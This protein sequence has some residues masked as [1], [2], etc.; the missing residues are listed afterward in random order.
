MV[1]PPA[2]N[3]RP[4]LGESADTAQRAFDCHCD[5]WGLLLEAWGETLSILSSR[6]DVLSLISFLGKNAGLKLIIGDM[7]MT[8]EKNPNAITKKTNCRK[9]NCF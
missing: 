1:L 3:R 9:N 7:L 6:S 8:L 5:S 2:G 4:G